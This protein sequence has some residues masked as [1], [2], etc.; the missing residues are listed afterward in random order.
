M[1]ANPTLP[2]RSLAL[3]LERGARWS[4]HAFGWSQL[5]HA[6]DGVARVQS[7]EAVW[8]APASRA[9]WLPAGSRHVLHCLTAL[10]LNTVYFPPDR[11]L[12]LPKTP[13]VLTVR[14][15]LRELLIRVS[16]TPP[17]E[18]QQT[19]LQRLIQVLIDEL[20][21]APVDA[22][23]LA[24]PQDS[25]ATAMAARMMSD[26]GLCEDLDAS[27][28]AVGASR[29]TLERLFRRETGL[30]LGT[31]RRMARMQ[32]AVGWLATGQSVA[33]TAER[34]GYLST[35]AFV[36]AFK[37]ATGTTPGAFARG[38]SAKPQSR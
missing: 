19:R 30:G 18:F 28:V 6:G 24:Q 27:I 1:L 29:R 33:N 10:T 37:A 7:A 23:R 17:A 8:V 13:T 4:D 32:R 26:E 35:P 12:P 22:L 36:E 11:D 5:V 25:R 34:V 3:R 2:I 15:L 31:W 20:A 9:V 21:D 14:P 38:R 16:E